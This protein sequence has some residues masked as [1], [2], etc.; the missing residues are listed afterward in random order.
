[1]NTERVAVLVL[2]AGF[3]S[4]MGR[5]KPLLP[6]FN[7]TVLEQVV[8]CYKQ[9]GI[10]DI[11]TVIGHRAEDLKRHI[12]QPEVT[13]VFNK[14]FGNGMF[15]SV[16]AGI[17]ML[18]NKF[19]AFF[20][21]PVDIPLVRPETIQTLIRSFSEKPGRIQIPCFDHQPGH[22]PL[23]P[24]EY[25]P[26][27]LNSKGDGG[28][29]AVLEDLKHNTV[30]I[31]VCD[32]HILFDIDYPHDYE[33]LLTRSLTWHLPSPK[34]TMAVLHCFH[35][36]DSD[37][38][39]HVRA[40]TYVAC[41]MAQALCE[42]GCML[43]LSLVHAGAML[44]DLGKGS[45]NHAE[46]GAQRLRALGFHD[47]ADIASRHLNLDPNDE[48]PPDEA[49]VVFLADKL[50]CGNR[51]T[52]IE[53]RMQMG[54]DRFGHDSDARRAIKERLEHAFRARARIEERTGQDLFQIIDYFTGQVPQDMSLFANDK[55]SAIEQQRP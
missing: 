1:M 2:A 33:A 27:V 6:L 36:P 18:D 53:K 42:S 51:L 48:Y 20:V 22:P 38:I 45:P 34:E 12:G 15:T 52:T 28:L 25:G 7:H 14:L 23:I 10:A 16:Q 46:V 3:A 17:R 47:V 8:S 37:V 26:V 21:H 32:E 44:H 41:R 49:E 50:I 43:N 9:A 13:P 40:V 30:M 54:L 24:I 35:R 4:R 55:R 19:D 11:F 5:F 31:E 39:A 29:K